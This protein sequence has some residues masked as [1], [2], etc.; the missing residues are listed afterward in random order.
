MFLISVSFA[1]VAEFALCCAGSD[2]R[3]N[4][5]TRAIIARI[6]V[7]FLESGH[8]FGLQAGTER[9]VSGFDEGTV[10][11]FEENGAQGVSVKPPVVE[12]RQ[13]RGVAGTC[14]L[15]SLSYDVDAPMMRGT[16]IP[17]YVAQNVTRQVVYTGMLRQVERD[18]NKRLEK[19]GRFSLLEGRR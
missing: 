17:V 3:A 15:R 6:A 7:D 12:N 4:L 18:K 16:T 2:S 10:R 9:Q 19:P 14:F 1:P 8:N 13:P 5:G 11:L